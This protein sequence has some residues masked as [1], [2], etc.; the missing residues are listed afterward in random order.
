[1]LLPRNNTFKAMRDLFREHLTEMYDQGEV[2]AIFRIAIEEKLI[3]KWSSQLLNE[4]FTESDINLISPVLEAL[5]T[6]RPL[7]YILGHTEFMGCKLKADE[8]VLIPR[9]ETEELCGIILNENTK[10]SALDV[11][12]IG[13]GSGCIPISLKK[14]APNWTVSALEV[15]ASALSLAMENA[16]DNAVEV[17]FIQQDILSGKALIGMYD[18]IVSNPP[19]IAEEEKKDIL[20]NVLIHEPHLALFVP[21]T[22]TL[23]FYRTI[24]SLAFPAMNAGGKLYFE[25]NERFGKETVAVM[26]AAGFSKCRV[27]KDLSGKDRFAVGSKP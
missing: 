11:L 2:D 18:I 4:R 24:S 5:A 21:D 3:V 1:M 25:I 26:K 20:D 10:T 14:H 8:R 9:P 15:D 6:G 19:Y 13:T 23:L 7:Q 12:D 17:H 22:D 16:K 27:I